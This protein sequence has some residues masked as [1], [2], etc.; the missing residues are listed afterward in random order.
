MSRILHLS[1]LG[2]GCLLHMLAAAQ[3]LPDPTRPPSGARVTT[4]GPSAAAAVSEPA[5]ILESVLIGRDRRIAVISGRRLFVGDRVGDA[6][7]VRITET[8]VVLR[9][10]E[11]QTTLKL[12]PLVEKRTRAP[13]PAAGATS[14]PQNKTKAP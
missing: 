2:F 11:G 9:S 3:A 5:P 12:F 10:G 14:R 1:L 6:R 4:E 7:I 8:E 13:A